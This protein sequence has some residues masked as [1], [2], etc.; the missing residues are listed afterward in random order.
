M[1]SKAADVDTLLAVLQ[2]AAVEFCVIGGVAAVAHGA[3]TPTRD[4]DIAAPLTAE[5]LTRLFAALAPHR[6]VHATRPDLGV[7]RDPPETFT[8]FRL[9]LL[10]TDL[11]RL[12]VLKR[13]EPIGEYEAL[14]T[15]PIELVERRVVP[16]L[17]LDQL[18][19]VKSYLT[20]PKDRIVAAELRAIRERLG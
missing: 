7:I 13:V 14:R 5:N 10:D 17:E 18:I 19:E 3:T 16:V 4:L 15:T 2:G 11:G 9:L 8:R 12:D 6:P 20:R 1:R